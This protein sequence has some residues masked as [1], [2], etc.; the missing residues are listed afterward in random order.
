MM[1]IPR[2]IYKLFWQRI[3]VPWLLLGILLFGVVLVAMQL[4]N[5]RPL[6]SFAVSALCAYL[7]LVLAATVICRRHYDAPNVMLTPLWSYKKAFLQHNPGA[8]GQILRNCFLL[9]PMGFLLP[10][11]TWPR[12][13]RVRTLLLSALACAYGI[14]LLQL[15][16]HRGTFELVDDPLDNLIGA[17][18]GYCLARLLLWA[19]AR[20]R[21]GGQKARSA[22]APQPGVP[23]VR[24]AGQA[25]ERRPL[26]SVI[27]GVYN[28]E[29]TVEAAV[30][31]ILGQTVEDLELLICDDCST[32]GTWAVLQR[33]AAQHPHK[34]RLL[35]SGENRYL[36]ASLNRCLAAAAGE[37][38]A[39]M[40]ADDVSLPDRLEK[41]L[42]FLEAHPEI[43]MVGTGMRM[44]M[45]WGGTKDL[46]TPARPDRDTMQR[47]T[48]FFHATLL[49]RRTVFDVLGGY[50][51][52][53]ATKRSEDIDF[54]CRFFLAGLHGANLQEMLYRKSET[55]VSMKS[56]KASIRL[57][58][59]R[60]KLRCYRRLHF[61]A[62]C[63]LVETLRLYK[64]LV[65]YP[66]LKLWR[67][68]RQD[69]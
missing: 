41:Q 44:V 3:S 24:E 58:S 8:R 10:L 16:L 26:I 59:Y 57:S 69:R 12:K 22:P 66:L 47:T 63:F 2:M 46:Y 68:L 5:E 29:D 45:D 40:D 37:Y 64:C 62:R 53:E 34:L 56:R 39:R 33:L 49:A 4:R 51:E 21:G 43:D 14:E 32:D 1:N 50:T 61:P 31:S 27:M 7:L 38:I 60:T 54:Y 17:A 20:L 13:C 15:V 11:C 48:P 25:P 67:R 19:V 65:P 42:R 18:A 28:C 23:D 9:F 6:R 35:R 30:Q 36:A 55:D 52:G